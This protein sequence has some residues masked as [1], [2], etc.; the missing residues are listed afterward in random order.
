VHKIIADE[1]H[2][3]VLVLSDGKYF[4]GHGIGITGFTTGEICFNTGLTGY[5]ET[6]TD[7]SYANQII[8]F[9]FPHIGNVGCNDNDKESSR[10]FCRGIV[11][12][13][14]IT[15]PSNYRSTASLKKWLQEHK[16]LGITNIDTRELTR[17]IGK[18]GALGALILHAKMG[19]EIDIPNLQQQVSS[20]P[21]LDGVELTSLVSTPQIY[22]TM[23]SG[24]SLKTNKYDYINKSTERFQVVVIDYGVKMSQ[25]DCLV[26]SGCDI[27]VVP[28]TTNFK[29]IKALNPDGIFLSNGP[30]DPAETY[31]LIGSTIKALIAANIP[32]F[33]ICLGHQLL[34]TAFNLSTIK[35][36]QG[37]RGANHPVKNLSNGKVE[38]TS[39]NHGFCVE[40]DDNKLPDNI[41]ITHISLFDRTL[42]G[43]EITN[44]PIFSVQ[45]HP[46]SSPGPL[47]SQY[48]FTKFTDNMRI[49][50]SS[51]KS[52]LCRTL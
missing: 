50:S 20:I 9:T 11:I 18:H 24:F 25:L 29:A 44:K 3:A 36:H 52:G 46:E 23:R 21:S 34:A 28:S 39:Q 8:T 45:Y 33:G 10:V 41:K 47:D 40:V 16:I 32:I 31:K 22:S 49:Y 19:E 2:N 43:I 12:G 35:M 30:G 4:L 26:M 48:L 14:D 1:F 51:L 5:Q 17:Y 38:I 7:P 13:N 15:N 27:T 37:H 6:L 42:E